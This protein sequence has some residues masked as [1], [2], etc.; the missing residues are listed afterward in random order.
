M[1]EVTI[2]GQGVQ[3]NN[4]LFPYE[5]LQSFWIFYRPGDIKEVSFRSQKIVMTHIKVPLGNQDP[6]TV[7]KLLLE[8]LPEK[9]QKELLIDTITRV[10]RF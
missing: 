5:T 4:R 2:S 1:I 3:I 9:P 6:N 10:L 7:R 8:F